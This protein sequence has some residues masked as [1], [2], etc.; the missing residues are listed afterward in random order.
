MCPAH[1][2]QGSVPGAR[3][4]APFS[5]SMSLPVVAV[6][7]QV[8]SKA[9]PGCCQ[10]LPGTGAARWSWLAKGLCTRCFS[11]F[12]RGVRGDL[13]HVSIH[14]NLRRINHILFLGFRS[15]KQ[16][17]LF[18]GPHLHCPPPAAAAP[19]PPPPGHFPLAPQHSHHLLVS[20]QVIYN[21]SSWR[22]GLI[23]DIA[24]PSVLQ[25]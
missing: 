23:S 5:S 8:F 13:Q 11:I 3:G 2:H 12:G 6:S 20:L 18:L 1:G 25:K 16:G 4:W 24:I 17:P 19:P 9:Q 15:Q 7:V 10:A 21:Q 14:L 22:T